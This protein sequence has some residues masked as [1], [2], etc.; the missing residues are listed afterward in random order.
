MGGSQ[1]C[2]AS[3][4]DGKCGAMEVGGA[5]WQYIQKEMRPRL[6]DQREYQLSH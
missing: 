4:A 1:K 2:A 3:V 6:A 5:V